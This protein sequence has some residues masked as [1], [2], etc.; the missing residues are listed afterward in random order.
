ML[1][2]LRELLEGFGAQEPTP[3]EREHAVQLATAVLLVEVMRAD[4][5]IGAAERETVTAALRRKFSLPENALAQLVA[6]AEQSAGPAYDYHRYS[7][8]INAHFSHEQKILIIEAMW[9]VAFV[10]TRLDEHENHLISKI[11]G[12]LH[13]THREYI[14]AKMHAKEAMLRR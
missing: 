4:S 7:S 1:K 3:A 14:G 6:Q 9:E 12:L 5:H 2:T 10:D 8:S 11:A 13:V